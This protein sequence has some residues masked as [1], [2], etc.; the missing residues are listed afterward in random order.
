MSAKIRLQRIG[1]KKKPYYKVVVMD[2]RVRRDGVAI[3]SLGR[4]NPIEDGV[5]FA[6][7]EQKVIGWLKKGARPT[8]TIEK[9]LKKAGVWRKY[10]EAR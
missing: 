10:K 8:A 1:K 3:E 9:L 7:D 2:E 5:Q 6:V 4:Y